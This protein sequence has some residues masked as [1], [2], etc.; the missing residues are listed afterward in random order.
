MVTDTK[1][2]QL[3]HDYF[4]LYLPKI[5]ECSAHTIRSYR[6]A[7]NAL[8][9]FVK[10]ENK[11][12]LAKVTLRMLDAKTIAYHL[13]DLAKNG[14]SVS[15][16]KLRL[17]CIKAFFS[18]AGE[19]EPTIVIHVAEIL[20]IKIKGPES[21]QLIDYLSEPAVK[22]LLEQPNQM[23]R[24]GLRDRFFL[25]LMYDAGARLQEIRQLRLCDIRW[26]KTV[27]VMLLGKGSKVRSVPLMQPTVEHL[28]NY[29][30]V[31]HPDCVPGKANY[32]E[33]PLFYVEQHHRQRP[34]SDSA[35]RK[36]VRQY[37]DAAKMDCPEIPEIVHPH[38]LRHSRAMHLY[39]HGMDI[40]LVQQW[41]GHAQLETTY[42][43]AYADTELKRKAIE[44]AT[45]A[46]NPIRSKIGSSRYSVSDEE[47]LRRLY[48][49][50]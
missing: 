3:I 9:D 26:G 30:G 28:K 11:V 47:T 44:K 15:T 34:L 13:E 7:I 33:A 22:A 45:A 25:L 1:L 20:K 10:T 5:R 21:K 19:V 8:L 42:Q 36:L 37:G 31:F 12:E 27:Y 49:L 29:L 6:T 50:S 16:R 2:F 18:Y 14:N 40:T 46:N 35:A 23:T 48:G 41:L 43:Y 39:Q 32:L 4:T 38:L 17:T 24:K